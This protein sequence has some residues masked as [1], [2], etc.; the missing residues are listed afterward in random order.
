MLI[1]SGMEAVLSVGVAVM[2]CWFSGGRD[3]DVRVEV[4]VGRAVAHNF[5][6]NIINKVR[7]L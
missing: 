2:F 5:T 6:I 3:E 1:E 7:Y 4:V